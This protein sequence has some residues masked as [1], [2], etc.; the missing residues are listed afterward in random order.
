MNY[1]IRKKNTT[2]H[3]ELLAFG[4]SIFI[5]ENKEQ[6]Q[7][8]LF[9]QSNKEELEVCKLIIIAHTLSEDTK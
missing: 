7:N 8:I 5:T 6:A 4:S 9:G 1:G 2:D 3:S